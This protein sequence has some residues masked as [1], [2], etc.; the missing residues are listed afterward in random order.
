VINDGS[1][2]DA[3]VE[4]NYE[5]ASLSLQEPTLAQQLNLKSPGDYFNQVAR[6]MPNPWQDE[7][8]RYQASTQP[9]QKQK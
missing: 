4:A 1:D 5:L 3:C 8:F 7:A 6:I 2:A 9:G